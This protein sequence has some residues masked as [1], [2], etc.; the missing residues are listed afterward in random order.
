MIFWLLENNMEREELKVVL[1]VEPRAFEIIETQSGTAR[2]GKCVECELLNR[3]F[4]ARIWLV[5]KDMDRPVSHLE[6]VN[7]ARE[8]GVVIKGN[9]ESEL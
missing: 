7:V 9:V 8:R 6:Y 2:K 3:F 1:V 4:T 5:I